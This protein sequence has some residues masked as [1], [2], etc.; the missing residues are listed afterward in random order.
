MLCELGS[1]GGQSDGCAADQVREQAGGRRQTAWSCGASH[2]ASMR[3]RATAI[4][5]TS[6]RCS[7]WCLESGTV[8]TN[9][10]RPEEAEE[11]G[12][13]PC[14]H[15]GGGVAPQAEREGRRAHDASD[16]SRCP[17]RGCSASMGCAIAT[18]SR[19]WPCVA[20]SSAESEL[21]AL[22]S[23]AVEALG[24]TTVLEEWGEPTV[25]VL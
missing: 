11:D 14:R 5:G 20:L 1:A 18:W 13:V 24:F 7:T 21:Y 2:V 6:C 4:G 9:D 23:G 17:G 19:R 3:G 8:G 22:G 16:R 25:P 15:E 10:E 12:A